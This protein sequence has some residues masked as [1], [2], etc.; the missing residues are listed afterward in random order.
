[1]KNN[2]KRLCLALL[3]LLGANAFAATVSLIKDLNPDE[4]IASSA[5]WYLGVAGDRALFAGTKPREQ[6][7][8]L[9][10]TDG[11][12]AG[13]VEFAVAGL[14]M[15][16]FPMKF[17]NRVLLFGSPDE[18]QF[19]SQV[20]ITDGTDAGTTMLINLGASTQFGMVKADANRAWFC[21][22]EPQVQGCNLYV[23][24]GTA[25][26]TR[27]L[28]T[29]Q[30]V[31]QSYLAPTGELYFF[32][33][34]SDGLQM[35]LWVSDGSTAGTR[36]L[37]T[38]ASMGISAIGPI[39]WVDGRTLVLNADD[40]TNQRGLF[41]LDIDTGTTTMLTSNNLYSF[42]ENAIE[43]GGARYFIMDFSLWR[44]DGTPAGTQRL[45]NYSL[46]YSAINP[47]VRIGNRLI[48]ANGDDTLGVEI[49][50][51]DGTQGGT[52]MLLDATPGMDNGSFILTATADRVFFIAGDS[53][54]TAG[55][56]LWVT[57]G[58]LPGTHAIP[59]AGGG[60]YDVFRTQYFEASGVAGSH[61]FFNVEEPDPSNSFL[62]RTSLWS[63][64]LSGT[65]VSRVGLGGGQIQPLGNR[66]FYAANDAT[67]VEPWV[68]DGT[69]AGTNRITDL[70]VSGQT[71]SSDPGDPRAVG[72]HA[73]FI[74]N[75]NHHGRELFVTDG[76]A[77]NTHMVRD[78]APGEAHGDIEPGSLL[79]VGD[80]LL[81][82]ADDDP[83]QAWLDQPWRSDGTEAGTFKLA[84]L[85]LNSTCGQWAQR[86]NGR[87]WFFA[88]QQY[89]GGSQL[90]STDG[91]AAGTRLEVTLDTDVSNSR[92]CD[93]TVTSNGLVFVAT[94]LGEP[95]LWRTDGT[96]GGT[97]RLGTIA[98]AE[99]S[100]Y[101]VGG[102][103]KPVNGIAYF[104]ADENPGSGRELWRTDGTSSG[105]TL[106]TDLTP[107][108]A[109]AR[110]FGLT[111]FGQGVLLTYESTDGDTVGLYQ[112][113]GP[114]A[115]AT[116]VKKGIVTRAM[117]QSI[118]SKVFF[119]LL[120]AGTE[121]L[122]VTD[123]TSAGTHSV[124]TA[125]QGQNLQIQVYTPAD[126]L[127][128]FY[129]ALTANDYQI[130]VT[131][132]ETGVHRVSHFTAPYNSIGYTLPL[133]K[134]LPLFAHWDVVTGGE[135]W[136]MTNQA[137][138][139]VADTATLT[140][141]TSQLVAFRAND[142]D[143]DTAMTD[144]IETITTQPAHGTLAIESGGWRYT[145]ASA[146]TGS[147]FFEY[148]LTDELGAQS[149]VARVTI[150]VNAPP[151]PAGSGGGGGGGSSGGGK[152]GGGGALDAVW[153]ALL[154]ALLGLRRRR[155]VRDF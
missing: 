23:T 34:S 134:G 58:T 67:G 153:L 105:T 75:D 74:A 109:G 131:D 137:P 62:N 120:D 46:P 117:P 22:A 47:L 154:A 39:A 53:L 21:A 124:I 99:P 89:Y 40:A 103:L 92:L 128:F 17:G 13:T 125:D 104:M 146:Y 66:M 86:W 44:S 38:F 80:L 28:T 107:G 152:G 70:A 133:F 94:P 115:G 77:A 73:F 100:V 3:G 76:T 50:V 139:A 57:D 36:M 118:G 116:L 112:V 151:P 69:L 16:R 143:A 90:W 52:H 7:S 122:W 136:I 48:F 14:A 96:A 144:V 111:Q 25:A 85:R 32:A 95:Q 55:Q 84:D 54:N 127:L 130:W 72:E 27:K 82:A 101:S 12:A 141:D 132:G 37:H 6:F 91:T 18:N 113:A 108:P 20:W 78:I 147:D 24:D 8:R 150:T 2:N 149:A 98:P 64:D 87:I 11:T 68:S 135:P 71:G 59:Q 9:F 155:G 129:G 5:P 10:R 93:L 45:T 26:G 65:N 4:V 42:A 110:A 88:S 119:V 49:W 31:G 60:A 97:L 1:M 121:S 102:W 41:S 35:G 138:V 123:G 145:P 43:M 30:G 126:G 33:V 19:T 56:Q 63:S 106:V 29:D 15:P 81:F 83:D 140:R 51:S 142:S 61:V 148:R 114:S 79:A